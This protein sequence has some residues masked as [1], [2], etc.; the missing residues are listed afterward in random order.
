[1]PLLNAQFDDPPAPG[2]MRAALDHVAASEAFRGSPQLVAFLRYVVE[3]TLRG[4]Q[5]RIKGYTIAVEALGRGD[6]FDPQEDPIV[7]VEATRLR[8]AM[9]KYYRMAASMTR[10]TST[11]GRPIRSRFPAL[12]W[13]GLSAGPARPIFQRP[14]RLAA[15]RDRRGAGSGWRGALRGPRLL[16]RLQYSQSACGTRNGRPA[17]MREQPGADRMRPGERDD[18]LGDKL[19][20][21][22]AEARRRRRH[23]LMQQSIRNYMLN[24]LDGCQA[25]I[26]R[27]MR[28]C[29]ISIASPRIAA[30]R[31]R[32]I[33]RTGWCARSSRARSPTRCRAQGPGRAQARRNP[34]ALSCARSHDPQRD[35]GADDDDHAAQSSDVGGDRHLQRPRGQHLLAPAAGAHGGKV[36]AAGAQGAVRG[37]AEPLGHNII[38]SVTNPIPRLTG[39]IHVYG[40][41]F[42]AA[43]RSEWDSNPGGRPLRRRACHAPLRGIQTPSCGE[44]P[45]PR[46]PPLPAT[47]RE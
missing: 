26:R 40:G 24:A 7:R 17:A 41:D 18:R 38:H 34:E 31:S 2:E 25:P 5:D 12:R 8:R 30:R 15:A 9:R 33:R 37:D 20:C 29:S 28:P 42:F 36:E 23:F 47:R 44:L 10:C 32:P 43:E 4:E 39:A 27:E 46:R 45:P 13:C 22:P 35:L 11:A 1:M 14:S 21:C 6:D 3:A 19:N 16:V